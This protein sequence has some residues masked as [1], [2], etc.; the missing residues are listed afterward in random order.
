SVNVE[1]SG[2]STDQSRT[3]SAAEASL[4]P[5]G[6]QASA[7]TVWV[8][9]VRRARRRNWASLPLAGDN[10]QTQIADASHVAASRADCGSQATAET[11]PPTV[12]TT[13]RLPSPL[14]MMS[15]PAVVPTARWRPSLLH[16][17]AAI[18][19]AASARG[20]ISI[21]SLPGLIISTRPSSSATAARERALSR[22]TAVA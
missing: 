14:T 4:L 17:R 19:L 12:V 8:W 21:V 15:W 11:L 3:S 1:R 9:L 2:R 7:A 5:F 18:L 10:D 22:A 16:A 20:S 6:A 13:S